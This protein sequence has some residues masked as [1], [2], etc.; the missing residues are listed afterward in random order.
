L[1]AGKT[2][3]L[4]NLLKKNPNKK[5]AIIE[6]EYGQESI[7]SELILRA[8]DD[9]IEINNGCLC[10]TLND[11][12]YDI[13]NTLYNRRNEYEELIIEATGVADPRGLAAP[14]LSNYAIKKQFPLDRIICLVDAEQVLE[15]LQNTEEAIHQI[16]FSDVLLINKTDL[17]AEDQLFH[18]QSLLKRL[19]PIGQI[20]IG[21]RDAYLPLEHLAH[22]S[23]LDDYIF[24]PIHEK[25]LPT[26]TFP[27]TKPHV[28]HDHDHTDG[29]AS[30]TL[31]FD[32]SFDYA[33][34][35]L[36]ILGFLT[37]QSSGLYRMKGLIWLNH[38]N[39]Q[40]L[41]QSVGS[42]L[43]IDE[44]R[45]WAPDEIRRSKIVVIGKGFQ[46]KSLLKMF[47][48]CFATQVCILLLLFINNLTL[49]SQSDLNFP[50]PEK[51]IAI[52]AHKITEKIKIDGKLEE[53]SW[54]KAE[55]VSEFFRQEPRQG[56]DIKY[57]TEVRFLYDDKYLYVGAICYD[58]LG[59]DGIRIQDLRR[60]FDWGENDIFG[61][62]LDPQNLKQYAQVFQTTPYGNQRDLQ[63]FNGNNFDTGWNT[64]WKV[65]TQRTDTGYVAEFAIPFK[66]LRYNM[67]H[68]GATL[69]W[70]VTLVRYARRDIEVSTFPPIPQSF[71]P[72]RMT[73]AA[74]IQ[75]IET[76]PRSSNIRIEPYT[77]FQ[78]DNINNGSETIS[79]N[80]IKLGGDVKWAINSE[81]VFDL[82]INTDFAQADVD[83]AVNNLERVNIFFPEQRQFF[84]ENS[85][86]WA[87]ASQQ[88]IR[89]FFSRR[90]GL[91]GNF[92]ASPAPIEL[93][94]RYTKRT[95]K[96]AIAGLLVR[97]GSTENSQVSN[98]GVARYLRNY[99]RENNVGVMI[100]HRIDQSMEALSI[101]G[102]NN[103]TLTFDGLFRPSSS[104]D[105]Q[106]FISTSIDER[107]GQTGYA[108]RF[109]ASNRSN[110]FYLGW[111]TDF[112]DASYNPGMGFIRQKNLISH[113]PR[114]YL[115]L[116]PKKMD[117]IRRWDPGIFIKY[118][119]DASEPSQF[120]QAS[121]VIFPIYTWF[122][123]NSFLEVTIFPTWQNINFNFAPL[124]LEIAQDNYYYTR[125]FIRYNTDQSKKWSANVN[126]NF[127]SF[128]NGTRNTLNLSGRLAPIPHIAF[129]FDYEYNDLQNIGIDKQ[130]LSTHLTSG[131]LRVAINPIL[132]FSSFYQYNSFD[133]QGRLNLR[134]S[135]E[136]QPLSFLYVVFNDTQTDEA[137]NP[138][139]QQQLVSKLTLIKQ[140]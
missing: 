105:I 59:T 53:S 110:K 124:G 18:L 86:I 14:F 60:D 36:R 4:N 133:G 37:F 24:E 61:I 126:Y 23:N 3:Y 55:I 28:H 102:N 48:Q 78:S 19:N 135:W 90:V 111:A 108:G 62:S 83:R 120:Q 25:P 68:D 1:G 116:R 70:G 65:R 41:L 33:Q 129:T 140:F 40:H 82:T 95:E 100:T 35:H 85:G 43:S 21:N 46:K 51:Q 123:D 125:F 15:Q 69:D 71:T 74:K 87:G 42:R 138:L 16:T 118:N 27:V 57:R 104:L 39:H 114:G 45:L 17:V 119:H 54:S 63:N 22:N 91:Q 32:R 66:S 52:S 75:G 7:D 134:A 10:C 72:Y 84:L 122:K 9:I 132:Q 130:N 113:N 11:N 115:I 93:G 13:L 136:Y 88:S 30:H 97:Q 56:G 137:F 109:F 121:L 77:L 6:N 34:L 117:W 2:T 127:G 31:I 12:L 103:T 67:S 112:I 44:K 73:Y 58:S 94:S 96:E 106:Y 49:K 81:A 98:F 5:Y 38:S 29:I 64:L 26:T 92:N 131:G 76:P 99:G 20:I 47:S 8:E 107:T 50:P 80:N 128:Y 101:D 79:D 139:S 89:P